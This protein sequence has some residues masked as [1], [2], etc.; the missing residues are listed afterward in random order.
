MHR[1]CVPKTWIS[2]IRNNT[3]R[4]QGASFMYCCPFRISI[5]MYCLPRGGWHTSTDVS[6][7]TMT[8]IGVA[9]VKYCF[10][11]RASFSCAVCL[12]GACLRVLLFSSGLASGWSANM[13]EHWCLLP[14]P[15]FK[16][17][18]SSDWSSTSVFLFWR[19][20]KEE[21]KTWAMVF[22]YC[23]PLLAQPQRRE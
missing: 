8:K 18:P 1:Q 2:R 20:L 16:L 22:K 23:F 5:C 13:I 12:L 7:L 14:L 21:T 11:Q 6:L 4:G 15:L 9:I 10:P 3:E 17:F 19:G